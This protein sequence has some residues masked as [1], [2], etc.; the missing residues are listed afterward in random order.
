MQGPGEPVRLQL[1]QKLMMGKSTVGELAMR[2]WLSQ[3]NVSKHLQLLLAHDM[4]TRRKE[5]L[6]AY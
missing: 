5:G 2:P 3:A 1:L 4:V 6:F